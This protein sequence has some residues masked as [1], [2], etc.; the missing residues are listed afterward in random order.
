[1][2]ENMPPKWAPQVAREKILELYSRDAK[3][4]RDEELADRVACAM[5]ARA[6]SI[7]KV[8][9][10]HGENILD[11]PSCSREIDGED[12]VF[13]CRC[14]Y[15]I[16]RAEL[17]KS[18]KRKQLVG[19]AAVPAIEKAVREFPAKGGY[20]EKMLW[21]D[22]LIHTFHGELNESFEETGLAYRPAARNFISGSLEQVV[23]LIF[24]LAY[25][26]DPEMAKTRAAW[27]EK[28]KR[29]YVPEQMRE[30]VMDL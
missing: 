13:E 3:G 28:L 25:G 9:K 22:S 8:T 27:I 6:E 21:I 2:N 5:L 18:Y 23:E 29:S 10:A 12:G 17:H 4:L 19:G 15:R 26:D 14:G 24:S 1:M 11:C 16:T 7:F 20:R 30:N